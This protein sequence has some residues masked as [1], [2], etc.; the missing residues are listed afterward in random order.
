MIPFYSRRAHG[1]RVDEFVWRGHRLIVMENQALRV[2]VLPSKGADIVELRYKPQDL[3]VLWHATQPTLPPGEAVPTVGR[4]QGNFL[5]YYSGAWQE[6]FPNAGSATTYRGA[7]LGQHGEVAL[8]PWDVRV[9]EDHE[10]RLE[11]EFTV[12]TL[13][14]P[15]RLNRRMILERARPVLI[16]QEEVTNL[17]EQGMYYQWGHHPVFGPPFLEPGCLLQMPDCEVVEP[18]YARDLNRRFALNRPGKFPNLETVE[19]SIDRVDLVPSI[20]TRTE[21]VLLFGG[22]TEG[23]CS[24]RNPTQ[25]LEVTMRWD[26]NVFPYA[27]C[28]QSYGGSWDYP[29][30]G[31]QYALALEPFSCPIESLGRLV[32]QGLAPRLGPGASIQSGLEIGMRES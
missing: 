19:G 27:W 5:D 15:F 25:K 3:D 28:W 9:N 30:Y 21:D 14:T 4:V 20:Q 11:V 29:F 10:S 2:S 26:A 24:L 32:E 8:L 17:S 18:D 16:L 1:C 6:V 12:E 22:F 31:R 7:Q 13:R 23:M